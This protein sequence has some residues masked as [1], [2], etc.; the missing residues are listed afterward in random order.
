MDNQTSSILTTVFKVPE[1]ILKWIDRFFEP[2]DIRLISFIGDSSLPA[3]EISAWLENQSDHSENINATGLLKRFHSRGI[4]RKLTEETYTLADFHERY[5]RW[6]VFEGWK[7][8][9]TAIQTQLNNWELLYYQSQHLSQIQAFK[10][11]KPRD[12]SQIWPEY[13]LLEEALALI[14]K[15]KHVFLWPCNCRAMMTLC[16]KPNLNCLRFEDETGLGWEISADR[17]KEIVRTSHKKGLMQSAEIAIGGDGSIKGGLC[18][19]CSDC[20]FPQQ[21][22]RETQAEHIWPL[23]RYNVKHDAEKC[24][25]CGKCTKRCAFR[26]FNFHQINTEKPETSEKKLVFNI[27]KCRGCGL[28]STTCPEEAI[29]M[30]P[31]LNASYSIAATIIQT[32]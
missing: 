14:D 8:V 26:A 20:C 30:K 5:D 18:N 4:V 24:S 16:S 25:G 22:A 19:C 11:G 15:V 9:P 2:I 31:G 29:E 12:T 6:A 27:D 28:C 21:L 13:V 10:D 32:D 23:N 7:D 17:A 3:S 1:F